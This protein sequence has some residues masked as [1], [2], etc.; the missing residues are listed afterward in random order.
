MGQVV[1]LTDEAHEAAKAF[2]KQ[3]GLKM[4]EWVSGLVLDAIARTAATGQVPVVG[5]YPV[6]PRKMPVQTNPEPTLPGDEP[7]SKPPFW[8]GREK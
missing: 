4:T 7:W 1:H 6:V 3:H 8:A 2:C 5:V